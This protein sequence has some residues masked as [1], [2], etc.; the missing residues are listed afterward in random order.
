MTK[1]SQKIIIF[2]A[3]IIV[4][5]W[6]SSFF[7]GPNVS[8]DLSSI[9]PEK[10]TPQKQK[11]LINRKPNFGTIIYYKDLLAFQKS[12]KTSVTELTTLPNIQISNDPSTIYV[13]DE[14]YIA[15]NI[16]IESTGN[17]ESIMCWLLNGNMLNNYMFIVDM[18]EDNNDLTLSITE[19]DQ[20]KG[21]FLWTYFFDGEKQI[22]NELKKNI[23]TNIEK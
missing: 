17:F 14:K 2:I 20:K 7:N 21:V 9:T 10:S 12:N 13:G 8:K 1:K 11:L 18:D 6:A 19:Y 16:S 5:Y 15:K 3:I 22:T 4:M 23:N